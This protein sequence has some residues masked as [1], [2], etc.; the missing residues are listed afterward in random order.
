MLTQG[1]GDTQ[2]HT[3]KASYNINTHIHVHKARAVEESQTDGGENEASAQ[4]IG[5]PALC[6]LLHFIM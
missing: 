2:T 3:K 1:G 4:R 5:P 6:S